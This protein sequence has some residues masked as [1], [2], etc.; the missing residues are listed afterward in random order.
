MSSVH[1]LRFP[2]T[3]FRQTVGDLND[4]QILNA[5]CLRRSLRLG[6]RL[7]LPRKF[8]ISKSSRISGHVWSGVACAAE[9]SRGPATNPPSRPISKITFCE[10]NMIAAES[11]LWG[12]ARI[13]DKQNLAVLGAVQRPKKYTYR[14]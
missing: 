4:I 7:N 5:E 12:K 2:T 8:R 13:F 10:G 1:F 9:F 14:L 11:F 3:E 6:H